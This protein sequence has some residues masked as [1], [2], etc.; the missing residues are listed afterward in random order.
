MSWHQGAKTE[1]NN[2]GRLNKGGLKL[3]IF[4]LRIIFKLKKTSKYKATNK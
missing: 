4:R 1:A 3:I 2:E